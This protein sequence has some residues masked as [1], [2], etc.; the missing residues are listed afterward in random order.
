MI[1]SYPLEDSSN[2]SASIS[3]ESLEK[4]N[5]FDF[6]AICDVFLF[7]IKGKGGGGNGTQNFGRPEGF[8]GFTNTA[9]HSC[10]HFSR[11][12][13]TPLHRWMFNIGV[14]PAALYK[15]PCRTGRDF[16]PTIASDPAAV[17]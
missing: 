10:L 14:F 7:S 6:G 9:D 16:S 2:T 12:E 8:T 15:Q 13:V 11:S 1:D 4:V 5:E 3:S 17:L